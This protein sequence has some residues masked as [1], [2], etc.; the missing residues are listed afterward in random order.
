[1][2]AELLVLLD[3]LRLTGMRPTKYSSAMTLCNA[4][5]SFSSVSETSAACKMSIE[6]TLIVDLER[7]FESSKRTR[8]ERRN[9]PPSPKGR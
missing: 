5:S 6:P 7:V 8:G 1:M 4:T 9:L 3:E 2:P